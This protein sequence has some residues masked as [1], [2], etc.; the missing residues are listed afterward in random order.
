[1]RATKGPRN[2]TDISAVEIALHQVALSFLCSFRAAFPIKNNLR[3]FIR[4][5]Q[6]YSLR[7]YFFPF[8]AAFAAGVAFGFG[9]LSTAVLMSS[10]SLLTRAALLPKSPSK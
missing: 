9:A 10:I 5:S 7:P 1:M 4:F 6:R 2:P 8:T 3:L